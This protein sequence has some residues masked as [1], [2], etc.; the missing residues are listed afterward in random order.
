M[1]L[2]K[3]EGLHC[4]LTTL[5]KPYLVMKQNEGNKVGKRHIRPH[6]GAKPEMPYLVENTLP[7]VVRLF[8]NNR[9]QKE[10]IIG[11]KVGKVLPF[12]N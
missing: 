8:R 10:I 5:K 2:A 6:L 1:T 12:L 4:L 9:G 11:G 3:H 7:D